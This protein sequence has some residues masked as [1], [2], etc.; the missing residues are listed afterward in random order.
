[1][2][3][4]LSNVAAVAAKCPVNSLSHW[5]ASWSCGWSQQPNTA[6]SHVAYSF[7]FWFIPAL[8]LIAAVFVI[9]FAVR[10]RGARFASR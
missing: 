5:Q 3:L 7:G 2:S 4:S 8:V 9:R 10:G 1:M 6:M